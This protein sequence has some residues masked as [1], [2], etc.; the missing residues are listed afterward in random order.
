[1]D[2]SLTLLVLF[3]IL[4][5]A[6]SIVQGTIG[7]GLGT[8][9]TPII[10]FFAPELIPALILMLA[11]VISTT[12]TLQTWRNVDW[13]FFLVCSIM[14]LPGTILGAAAVAYL[15]ERG[16]MAMIGIAIL[17]S[18][19]LSARGWS[20]ALNNRNLTIA[21]VASGFLGTSTALGGPPLAILLKN[22]APALMRGTLSATFVSGCIISLA[23]LAFTGHITRDLVQIWLLYLP[24]VVLGL[25]IA[26]FINQRINKKVLNRIVV[27]VSVSAALLLLLKA[28][29]A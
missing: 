13:H 7:F 23:S 18:M 24:L 4:I 12:T 6:G 17:G 27:T 22:S 14:R 10:A 1:M 8:L 3:G 19:T 29:F 9:A 20:P 15:P 21:S 5:L 28:V 16:L 26:Y 25:V 11:L 2:I